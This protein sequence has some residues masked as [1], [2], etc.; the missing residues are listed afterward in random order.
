MN[1]VHFCITGEYM[2]P[3]MSEWRRYLLKVPRYLYLLV[4]VCVQSIFFTVQ[5]FDSV[6]AEDRL[7]ASSNAI[8]T[9]RVNF[10]LPIFMNLLLVVN[11]RRKRTG[12]PAPRFKHERRSTSE[13]F[14]Q[15][16]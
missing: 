6:L 5:V 15:V 13:S 4:T 9:P 8:G 2:V 16:K 10:S 3:R 1:K 11:I 14:F 7:Y 12:Q